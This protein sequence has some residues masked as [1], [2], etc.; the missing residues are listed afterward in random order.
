[1]KKCA[2][3]GEEMRALLTSNYCPNDCDRKEN[4]EWIN[5]NE[6]S[7]HDDVSVPCADWPQFQL[8]MSFEGEIRL[9]DIF[10]GDY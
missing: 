8:N 2:N 3:C 9:A 7:R 1:M 10:F 6:V 4:E 5:I